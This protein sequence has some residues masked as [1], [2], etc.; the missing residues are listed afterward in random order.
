MPAFSDALRDG[1]DI[2]LNGRRGHKNQAYPIA[3]PFQLL[4]QAKRLI[5]GQRRLVDEDFASS[6]CGIEL[7]DDGPA[8]LEGGAFGIIRVPRPCDDIGVYETAG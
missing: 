4:Q 8:G 6:D 5:T 7:D 2:E 3:G 1:G